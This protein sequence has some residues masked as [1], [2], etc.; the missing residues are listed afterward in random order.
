MLG[1]F[2]GLLSGGTFTALTMTSNL[3]E[4]MEWWQ[5]LL[6]AIAP[7]LVGGGIDLLIYILKAKKV[8]NPDD[9]D[10]LVDRVHSLQDRKSKNVENKDEKDKEE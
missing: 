10:K 5:T 2:T 8:I 4:G 6:V 7:S 9:A 3:P 1:L